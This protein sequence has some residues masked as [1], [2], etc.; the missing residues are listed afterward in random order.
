M[1]SALIVSFATQVGYTLRGITPACRLTIRGVPPLLVDVDARPITVRKAFDATAPLGLDLDAADMAAIVPGKELLVD[2]WIESGR[3]RATGTPELIA[4][5]RARMRAGFSARQYAEA[6]D[7]ITDPRFVFI[8][9]GFVE[10]DG[11]DDFAWVADDDRPWRY[12]LNL[13]RQVVRNVPLDGARVL[14][15]SCG[16]GGTSAYLARYHAP[17]EVVGVDLLPGHIAFCRATHTAP[18]LRFIE[19]DAQ[20]LPFEDASFDVVTNIEASHAYPQLDLFLAEVRRVL[21]PGGILCLTDN[22][23]AGQIDARTE[24]LRPYGDVRWVRN[25][26]AEVTEALLQAREPV[27]ELVAD[28]VRTAGPQGAHM[29]RFANAILQCRNNYVA[30]A[31]EY[32]SW[33]VVRG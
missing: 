28:M 15:V 30:G 27:L 25:I 33:Q 21:R 1:D 8:N 11:S 19:A 5:L 24:R 13:V 7:Q 9:H 2:G 31:W 14:D 16:R 32:G 23:K 29:E 10:L 26:T 18:N 12:N 17:A 4:R 6:D 3:I 22:V 20:H